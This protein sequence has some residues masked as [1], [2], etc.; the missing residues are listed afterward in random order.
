VKSNKYIQVSTEDTAHAHI[1]QD[2]TDKRELKITV[3]TEV[4]CQLVRKALKEGK[5]PE[6][7]VAEI[8]VGLS[9]QK[10]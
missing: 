2:N 5:S 4:Y 9:S 7:L 10:D 6:K 3:S 1:S 8:V